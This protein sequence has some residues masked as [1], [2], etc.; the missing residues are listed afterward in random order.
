MKNLYLRWIENKKV[1]VRFTSLSWNLNVEDFQT[2]K[3]NQ[4]NNNLGLWENISEDLQ[5][6]LYWNLDED[7]FNNSSMLP[8]AAQYRN[9]PVKIMYSILKYEEY[10][11]PVMILPS[12]SCVAYDERFVGYGYT[13]SSFVSILR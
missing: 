12:N 7:P 8:A 2:W 6:C 10:W 13:R 9:I 11:E 1:F 3:R 5:N 4:G